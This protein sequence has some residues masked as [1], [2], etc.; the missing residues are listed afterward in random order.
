MSYGGSNF[1][2]VLDSKVICLWIGILL[3]GGMDYGGTESLS[4]RVLRIPMGSLTMSF[5]R[6]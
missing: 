5:D 3:Y 1:G 4:N 2:Q 6:V